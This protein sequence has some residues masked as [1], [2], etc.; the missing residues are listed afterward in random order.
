MAVRVLVTDL[1]NTLFDWV[2]IWYRS[3]TALLDGLA[4][5]SGVPRDTLVDEARVV[6][7][8]HGTS[9]YA[10][11][12]QELPSLVRLHPGED[13]ARRYA[14]AITAFKEARA[15]T[16]RLYPGVRETLCTLRA[17]GC[18]LVGYTESLAYYTGYRVRK[19]AL[20]GLLDHL[21]SP[22]DHA[23]PR[24]LTP[25]QLRR[26][27]PEY[28]RFSHT[29]HHELPAGTHKPDAR[30][31]LRILADVGA[32]L[33]DALYVGDSLMKDVAMAQ[34]AGVTDVHAAYGAAH[35]SE[36]YA[37]LRRVTHWTDEDVAR[38]RALL[39]RGEI[40]PSHVLRAGFH[41]LLEQFEFA[42]LRDAAA[43]GT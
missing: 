24:G 9:E 40:V 36:A 31:L 29:R 3:F 14:G 5:E 38:E 32:E 1:D 8:R 26:H 37:L 17:R 13:L 6:H 2:E 15:A 28:Y 33:G 27:P 23:L 10:F 20:D 7:Q 35:H 19:L 39:E 30:V 18:M 21:Y 11:L 43:A 41:E 42:S 22:A 4:W 25:D 12:I 16:L 34:D